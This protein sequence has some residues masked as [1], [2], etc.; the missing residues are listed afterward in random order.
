MLPRG[1][2]SVTMSGN[3]LPGLMLLASGGGV[4]Q[5]EL[6]VGSIRPEAYTRGRAPSR[7]LALH[8]G[9]R[10]YG[11]N[12]QEY[13]CNSW[14]LVWPLIRGTDCL[15]ILSWRRQGVDVTQRAHIIR[16]GRGIACTIACCAGKFRYAVVDNE[17]PSQ[18]KTSFSVFAVCVRQD[19]NEELLI[20]AS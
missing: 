20:S 13:C 15:C 9:V 18:P 2:L 16:F 12:R 8:L 4:E 19:P 1:A 10:S 17:M 6:A 11:N 14:I 7:S 5:S 3:A